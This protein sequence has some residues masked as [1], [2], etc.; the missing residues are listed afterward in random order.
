MSTFPIAERLILT[1]ATSNCSGDCI[2]V[3]RSPKVAAVAPK[4]TGVAETARVTTNL[5]RRIMLRCFRLSCA[6]KS[7]T[8]AGDPYGTMLTMSTVLVT[9]GSGFIGSHCILQLLAAGH[10]VRT[11]VRSLKREADVRAMLK[12]GGAEPGDRLSFFAAELEQDA[13]WRQAVDG[14]AYVLHVASPLSQDIPKNEDE[15]I[16]PARD[17]TLRVLRAA[18]DAGVK[19]VVL[20]S[21]FAAIGYGHAPRATPFDETSWTDTA[22][23]VSA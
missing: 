18:R 20:T 14:C 10:R 11:T 1:D 22:A 6:P 16:V 23:P 2:E 21:S 5:E 8:P 13:G 9:G 4:S 17:G 7:T 12:Q 3:A 15:M 19:R